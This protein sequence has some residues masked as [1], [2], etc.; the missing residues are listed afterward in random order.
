[1]SK[2]QAIAAAVGLG[3]PGHRYADTRHNVGFM[4]VDELARRAG[5]SWQDKFKAE[6]C[7]AT[8]PVEGA[9]TSLWLLKPQTFMNLSGDPVQRFCAFYKLAPEQL[10][11]LHDEID[12][13]FGEL[14]LKDGGGHRGHNGLRSIIDRTGVAGFKRLRIGVG[15][16]S[17]GDPGD[18][19]LSPFAGDDRIALP[20]LIDGAADLVQAIGHRGFSAVM[21][22]TRGK[23]IVC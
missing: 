7:R 23:V 15:R 6:H 22:D 21:H 17:K 18:Y 20:T 11:V 9:L 16:P 3:N 1:M 14:R 12:L 8:L 19:V 2:G 13:P 4:V 10:L 5:S